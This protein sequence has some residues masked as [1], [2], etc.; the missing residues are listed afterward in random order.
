MLKISGSIPIIIS[1]FF[2]L[3][4]AAIGWMNTFTLQGTAIWVGLIFVSVLVHE[5]GHA[6]TAVA[7][8]QRAFIEL[9]GFGGITKRRGGHIKPWQEFIVVLNG[10]LAG[11]VL[12]GLAWWGKEILQVSHPQSVLT[13]VVSMAF[14]VNVF[15]TV[16]NLLPIQPL[17]G[18][19]LLSI[20]LEGIFGFRGTKIALFISLVLAAGL[21]V[22]FFVIQAFLAGALFML[23]TYEAYR[24]WKASLSM[25]QQDQNLILQHLLKEVERDLHQGHK[26]EAQAKLMQIREHA[27][28]GVI[29]VAATEQLAQLWAEKG[30]FQTAYD[31]LESVHT[32]LSIE[33]LRLLHQL[34]YTLKKWEQ[35][36]K[37]GDGTYQAN[38]SYQTALINATSHSMLAQVR[39]AIGWLHCAL[40]DGAPNLREVL[41]LHEFD[42]IRNDPRFLEFV[43]E[44]AP[45]KG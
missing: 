42:P 39:P 29:Y 16:I 37:L 8:G 6:L 10:P 35:V 28:A 43:N 44:L 15:W 2:W 17:D 5:F 7:F 21:S 13:Y 41:E 18:G 34:A 45:R 20:A 40:R 23:F 26:D 33:A 31:L 1:P 9:V 25:T 32:K 30:E 24:A 22:F 14:Y 27:K 38:P 11:C 19:K 3:L 12:C 36:A 4:A